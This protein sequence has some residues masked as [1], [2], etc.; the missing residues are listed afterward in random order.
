MPSGV[1]EAYI[2][3]I[4]VVR[5]RSV[6]SIVSLLSFFFFCSLCSYRR[7]IFYLTLYT[8][9]KKAKFE[10][11]MKCDAL[12]YT[13]VTKHFTLYFSSRTVRC[14][15]KSFGN[16]IDVCFVPNALVLFHF[17]FNTFVL[18][19]FIAHVF[20]FFFFFLAMAAFHYR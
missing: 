20:G 14:V 19:Y 6:A 4:N 9:T 1:E 15:N 3:S 13:L 16:K 2:E 7:R 18:I 10:Y 11:N 17:V 12:L 5:E 8:S